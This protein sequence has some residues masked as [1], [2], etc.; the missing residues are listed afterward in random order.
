MDKAKVLVKYKAYIPA[1]Q[2]S[3]SVTSDK[4]LYFHIPISSSIKNVKESL[5]GGGKNLNGHPQT[6]DQIV[7]IKPTA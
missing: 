3:P 6:I 7:I 1:V 2:S 4:W 5:V